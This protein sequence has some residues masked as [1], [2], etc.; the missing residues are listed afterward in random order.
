MEAGTD[1]AGTLDILTTGRKGSPG[2]MEAG[3]PIVQP[4]VRSQ[5][6]VQREPGPDGSRDRS[7]PTCSSPAVSPVQREPGPDGSRDQRYRSGQAVRYQVQ[8]EP[9]PDGSRD[10][11]SRALPGSEW[12]G[13]EGA[14]ARWKPGHSY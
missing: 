7:W 4:I 5:P 8:R 11:E 3:T 1:Y 9:G 6:E 14:R 10:V 2:P 12:V 13:A